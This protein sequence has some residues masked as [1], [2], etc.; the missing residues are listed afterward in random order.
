MSW[1]LNGGRS[2]SKFI[3]VRNPKWIPTLGTEKKNDQAS[4]N[5]PKTSMSG[6]MVP[7]EPEGA[8]VVVCHVCPVIKRQA[9]QRTP[10]PDDCWDALLT[11]NIM[12]SVRKINC[13]RSSRRTTLRQ[14]EKK[15]LKKFTLLLKPPNSQW[16][17]QIKLVWSTQSLWV[18]IKIVSGILNGNYKLLGWFKTRFS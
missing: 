18:I 7:L 17:L 15:V 3:W 10:Y 4:C 2:G 13:C 1:I 12:E 6:L 5:S 11:L 9:F 16:N 8:F 14:L